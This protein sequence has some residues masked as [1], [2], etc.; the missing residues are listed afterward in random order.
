MSSDFDHAGVP[1]EKAVRC[2]MELAVDLS[3]LVSVSVSADG[4]DDQGVVQKKI[5]HFVAHPIILLRQS[6][7][8]MIWFFQI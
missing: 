8:G 5:D 7:V 4:G 3:L 6:D 1:L 2:V